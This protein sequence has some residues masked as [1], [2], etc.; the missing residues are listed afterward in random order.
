MRPKS[1]KEAKLME[2]FKAYGQKNPNL[3]DKERRRIRKI[4]KRKR[5]KLI[6]QDKSFKRIK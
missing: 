3:T 6:R 1:K 4:W 2:K 5:N